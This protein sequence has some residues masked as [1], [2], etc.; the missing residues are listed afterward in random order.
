V[1][2]MVW[3]LYHATVLADWQSAQLCGTKNKNR[4]PQIAAAGSMGAKK[5]TIDLCSASSG[6]AALV[7]CGGQQ[8]TSVVVMA[9]LAVICTTLWPKK[10]CCQK[11][12]KTTINLC[13][14]LS[15]CQGEALL[16]SG[17]GTKQQLTCAVMISTTNGDPHNFVVQESKL[18][19]VCCFSCCCCCCWK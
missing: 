9:P 1:L 17:G 19:A 13:R 14:A 11:N 3:H 15:G 4:M 5:T 12:I 10:L 2:C 8:F 18:A 7:C 16:H 6:V